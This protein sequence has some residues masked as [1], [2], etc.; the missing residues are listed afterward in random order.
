MK[1]EVTIIYDNL[2]LLEFY[3]EAFKSSIIF[4]VLFGS[5]LLFILLDI[6]DDALSLAIQSFLSL[7]DSLIMEPTFCY[8][9]LS[10]FNYFI[11][12]LAEV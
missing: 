11:G 5:N 6:F 1:I 2:F 8:R 12:N 3:D 9:L 4:E 7:I 10:I